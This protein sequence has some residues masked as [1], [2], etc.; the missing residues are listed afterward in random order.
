MELTKS[1]GKDD[2]IMAHDVSSEKA[3]P[4]RKEPKVGLAENV[5]DEKEILVDEKRNGIEFVYPKLDDFGTYP[6]GMSV[7][8]SDNLPIPEVEPNPP[9][10][11]KKKKRKRKNKVGEMNESEISQH[12]SSKFKNFDE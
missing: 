12:E 10:Q 6:P 1:N 5:A 9:P 4:A 2:V 7:T 8:G 11:S 3:T